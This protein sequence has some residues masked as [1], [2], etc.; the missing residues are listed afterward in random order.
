MDR[1]DDR[2]YAGDHSVETG[3][4]ALYSPASFQQVEVWS[5]A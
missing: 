3:D 4:L 2:F 1:Y 5:N